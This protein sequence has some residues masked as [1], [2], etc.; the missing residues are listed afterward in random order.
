MSYSV[1]VQLQQSSEIRSIQMPQEKVASL[2]EAD[3]IV[4][5]NNTRTAGRAVAKAQRIL[6][7]SHEPTMIGR[8]CL[9]WNKSNYGLQLH[10][11]LPS[12]LTG[13]VYSVLAQRS[14]CGWQ[15]NLRS[16][17][18]VGRFDDELNEM[19]IR[20]D[21]HAVFK[22]LD[23]RRMTPFVRERDGQSLL[24]VTFL[25]ASAFPKTEFAINMVDSVHSPPV[26]A[27]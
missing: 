22:F 21:A 17:E 15:L 24:Q 23:D 7:F 14:L 2:D 10:A 27:N 8:L 12:W 20:D 25:F 5:D 9:S 26:L 13:S 1:M 6:G 19:I 4:S 11:Q 16:Y 18:V 3:D